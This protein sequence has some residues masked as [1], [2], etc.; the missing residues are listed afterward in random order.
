MIDGIDVSVFQNIVDW[1]TVA[2]SKQF[3]ICRMAYGLTKDE[4][5]DRNWKG[6]QD[7][8]LIRGAYQFFRP[9]GDPIAQAEYYAATIKS[10]T[11]GDLPPII[12][13]E[14]GVDK[15]TEEYRAKINPNLAKW[16]EAIKTA[17]KV[18]PIIYTA[19]SYWD[20]VMGTENFGC[21]LWVANYTG[22]S[23]PLLPKAWATYR[24]WQHSATGRVAGVRDGKFDCDLDRYN[25]TLDEMKTWLASI[26]PEQP[27]V[28]PPQEPHKIW[29]TGAD[30]TTFQFVDPITISYSEPK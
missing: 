1:P 16:I 9:L 13:V 5:F 17:L 24:L 25:G 29:V 4:Q 14:R 22:A 15:I 12:D 19:Q 8:G 27:P 7:A 28:E 18:T 3:A 23:K 10:H 6:I 26:S 30:R 2:K 21:E 11:T 20:D